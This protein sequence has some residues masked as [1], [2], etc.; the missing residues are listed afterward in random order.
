MFRAITVVIACSRIYKVGTSGLLD[1]QLEGREETSSAK[2]AVRALIESNR[3]ESP[4][5]G[6]RYVFPTMMCLSFAAAM[7][8][9]LTKNGPK[10]DSSPHRIE[11]TPVD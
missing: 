4:N 5:I 7:Y 1:F 2:I 6:T 10:I 3:I 11:L 9:R 8:V